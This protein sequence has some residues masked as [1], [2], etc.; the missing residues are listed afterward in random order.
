M[1]LLL[2]VKKTTVSPACGGR[3]RTREEGESG[4]VALGWGFG[5]YSH[6]EFSQIEKF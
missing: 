3:R 6:T 5:E 2:V 1:V 4:E